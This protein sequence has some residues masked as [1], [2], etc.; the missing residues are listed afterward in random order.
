MASTG[1]I[2]YYASSSFKLH[3]S[4]LFALQVS[5]C[6]VWMGETK[7]ALEN[8]N[9]ILIYSKSLFIHNNNGTDMIYSKHSNLWSHLSI[10]I[11]DEKRKKN[12]EN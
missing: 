1:S 11:C 8:E 7:T 4:E 10:Y 9:S 6:Q 5:V 3:N 2:Q 12:E